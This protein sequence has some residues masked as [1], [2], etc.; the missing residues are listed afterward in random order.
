MEPERLPLLHTDPLAAAATVRV[1]QP[2]I[3]LRQQDVKI[4]WLLMNTLLHLL[5]PI[6]LP[7]N[8]RASH[9]LQ[10]FF[11]LKPCSTWKL[12]HTITWC[13]W[14]LEVGRVI[15]VWRWWQCWGKWGFFTGILTNS[16]V[17]PIEVVWWKRVYEPPI[18]S[19][20]SYGYSMKKNPQQNKPNIQLRIRP[21][22]ASSNIETILSKNR[23]TKLTS[24][25]INWCPAWDPYNN[26]SN[27]LKWKPV[28]PN[29]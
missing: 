9:W 17:L 6:A 26:V 22:A 29:R 28:A 1:E 18:S 25:S 24:N 10:Y 7:P 3:D 12:C 16:T 5:T 21:I 11:P 14:R 2:L 4:M 8:V 19:N 20:H 27:W 23:K 15:Y 13:S